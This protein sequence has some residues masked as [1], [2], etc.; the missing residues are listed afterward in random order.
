MAG[1]K[2]NHEEVRMKTAQ[3][4]LGWIK[5]LENLMLGGLLPSYLNIIEF[6]GKFPGNNHS[7]SRYTIKL[8]VGLH[9]NPFAKYM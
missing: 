9:G 3:P 8:K 2:T 1:R 5:L 7:D 6:G 4:D